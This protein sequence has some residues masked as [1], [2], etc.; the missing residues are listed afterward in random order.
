M[1]TGFE[2]D[3]K[4]H[5]VECPREPQFTIIDSWEDKKGTIPFKSANGRDSFYIDFKI[6]SVWTKKED[7]IIPIE[8]IPF[9]V[10]DVICVYEKEDVMR[11]WISDDFEIINNIVRYAVQTIS[12]KEVFNLTKEDLESYLW[13]DDGGLIPEYL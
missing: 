1:S 8:I 10:S 4:F 9:N 13:G 2:I 3:F 11:L 12:S 7:K 6:H 5:G